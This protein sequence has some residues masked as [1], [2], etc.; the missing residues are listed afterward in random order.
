MKRKYVIEKPRVPKIYAYTDAEKLVKPWTGRRAS[1]HGCLKVGY[2]TEA[3]AA[4]RVK[5]AQ[6]AMGPEGDKWKIVVEE[7]AQ[8]DDGQYFNDH[9]VHDYLENKMGVQRLKG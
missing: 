6:G 5:A 1:G 7:L 3:I 4:I 8:R 2:T 9:A